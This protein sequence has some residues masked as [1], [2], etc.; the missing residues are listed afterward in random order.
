[1]QVIASFSDPR[2]A[3]VQA[4][5]QVL[6]YRESGDP[7]KLA[8]QYAKDIAPF[9]TERAVAKKPLVVFD[10]DDTLINDKKDAF[11]LNP[12][13]VALYDGLVKEGAN[14]HLVSARNNDK[15]TLQWSK[16]QLKVLG[17][18]GYAGLWHAPSKWRNT[19]A[20]ISEW[21]R[22]QRKA[23]AKQYKSPVI[24]TVGDQWGDSLPLSSDGDI[25][26]M[27][28][29]FKTKRTPWLLLRPLD[30][31]SLWGLKLKAR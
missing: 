24:L 23:L 4:L 7:A 13:V 10:I 27:D 29:E 15:D 12:A 26:L 30:G 16:D 21:K 2:E 9:V 11:I 17:I 5:S 22:D 19:M 1:M 3:V 31:V 28:K 6:A 14:V 25:D 8:A 18:E 20:K